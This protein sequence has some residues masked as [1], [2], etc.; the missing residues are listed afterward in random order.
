MP[1]AATSRYVS[2]DV[3]TVSRCCQCKRKTPLHI[4]RACDWTPTQGLVYNIT[5]YKSKSSKPSRKMTIFQASSPWYKEL[6]RP[7]SEE[8]FVTAFAPLSHSTF[9]LRQSHMF[10]KSAVA[11]YGSA[12]TP[13]TEARKSDLSLVFAFFLPCFLTPSPSTVHYAS[14]ESGSMVRQ[15]AFSRQRSINKYLAI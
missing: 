12:A 11:K 14:A 8:V 10:S 3:R 13:K 6:T 7:C 9:R 5:L 4:E 2:T 15:A 1:A